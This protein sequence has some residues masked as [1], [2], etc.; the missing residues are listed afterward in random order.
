MNPAHIS[1]MRLRICAACFDDTPVFMLTVEVF[2]PK[3]KYV[4]GMHST[5]FTSIL[6]LASSLDLVIGTPL[7][8]TK[9]RSTKRKS[10]NNT[11]TRQYRASIPRP[12]VKPPS[13]SITPKPTKNAFVA[14]ASNAATK[15]KEKK[16]KNQIVT[17]IK[18]EAKNKATEVGQNVVDQAGDLVTQTIGS[19]KD[20][21]G[22]QLNDNHN[23]GQPG[24]EESDSS[25]QGYGNQSEQVADKS[26]PTP[27]DEGSKTEL[28]Q[29]TAEEASDYASTD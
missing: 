12:R 4:V 20:Y 14:R 10:N 8:K 27:T 9:A 18:N 2:K 1:L 24:Q 19:S 28:P 17:E 3:K 15:K 23:Q 11:P 26:D 25:E 22:S 6:L 21:I 7:P 29:E 5:L 16:P 13:R